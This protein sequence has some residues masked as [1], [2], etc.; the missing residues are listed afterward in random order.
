MEVSGSGKVGD[1]LDEADS[2]V[3]LS[4]GPAVSV[5]E[6]DAIQNI[7][8]YVGTLS[9]YDI[10]DSASAIIAGK[11]DIL[12]VDGVDT[13]TVSDGRLGHPMEA[14][15]NSF[16]AEVEFDVS[17]TASDIAAEVTGSGKV[18]DELDEANSVMVESG[19][20][21]SAED[22]E[23]IIGISGYAGISSDID[24]ADDAASLISANDAVLNATGVDHIRVDGGIGEGGYGV[25]AADGAVLKSF[26]AEIDFDVVDTAQAIAAEVTGTDIRNLA[27]VFSMM[28]KHIF[29][30][31]GSVTVADANVI[32]NISGYDDGVYHSGVDY[33]IKDSVQIL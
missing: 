32:Q 11:D 2:V 33:E 25:N 10:S 20:A 12:N 18:G 15:I 4:G 30:T 31:G 17:A 8:E 23:A 21:V 14:T 22:A 9:D 5:A 16:A 7:S 19:E 29:I 27:I 13:V 6:A 28:Q 26:S 24:I 1:E 3:V